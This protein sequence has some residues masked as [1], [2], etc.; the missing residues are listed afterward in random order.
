M[1]SGYTPY[2]I[3]PSDVGLQKDLDSYLI[4]D[5]AF[6]NLDNAYVRRGRVYKKGGY[7]LLGQG[8]KAGRLGTRTIQIGVRSAGAD[9]YN[10][11][12]STNPNDLTIEPGSLIITDGTTTFTDNGTG[13]FTIT[14][15]GVVN[16]P[17]NYT[18]SAINITFSNG[19]N[20]ALVTANYIVAVNDN[21]PVMGLRTYDLANSIFAGLVAFDLTSAYQFNNTTFQF[22]NTRFYKSTNGMNSNLV[23]WSGSDTDFFDS[24]NYQNAMFATNN[25]A[26]SNFYL[27][28]AITQAAAAQV[29][30]SVANNFQAGDIVYFNNVLG[31][32]QINNLT[33]QV[34]VAGNPFTVMINT[35][36]FSAYTNGSGIAWSLVNTKTAGGDG[37]RW[38]D[39]FTAGLAPATGW[40]NFEPP[41][42]SSTVPRPRILQGCLL[43]F[44][45]KDR[46]VCLNTLE[47]TAG[48][49]ATRFSQRAR[50]S[51][52]GNVFYAA[53]FPGTTALTNTN[54]GNEWI[55][56]VPGYGGFRDAPTGQEIIGAELIKDTLVVYFDAST[57]KLTFTGDAV[58]PFIWE[59]INTEIGAESTFSI[60]PFD[61]QLLSVGSNGI[62]ACDSV[63]MERIDR[64]IPDEVFSFVTNATNAKR[65]QGVRDFYAETVQWTFLDDDE[66]SVTSYPYKTLLFNYVNQTFAIFYNSFTCFG[67]FNAF[68]DLEWQNATKPWA[69]YNRTW[70]SFTDTSGFPI[71]VA[72]N[73]QGF[74]F[75]LQNSAGQ[76]IAYNDTSL[77]IQGVTATDPSVFTSTNHNLQPNDFIS[78]VG[79]SLPPD[80]LGDTYVV[81]DDANYTANT[82]ALYDSFGNYVSV[83]DYTYGGQI[84]V[85]DNFLIGTKNF[86]PFFAQGRSMRL[87]Y[88]DFFLDTSQIID[89]DETANI[90]VYLYQ[91]DDPDNPV[92]QYTIDT[93]NPYITMNTKA[94]YRVY[95]ESQGQFLKIVLS[96]SDN[97][98]GVGITP[99]QMF[100]YNNTTYPL[101][102]HGMILWMKPSGRDLYVP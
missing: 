62:Y 24:V 31:M 21:S 43:M 72:G 27:I 6:T 16:G 20:G 96:L 76:K 102:L 56:D 44:V 78:F 45:Y 11:T 14:G 10:L 4:P 63:S 98:S 79:A 73:Q 80:L 88:A 59:K 49:T 52:V 29:T 99:G 33:G 47:S 3:G 67:H 87:G 91:N 40:V 61:R 58:N 30:T 53:P 71:V 17:T 26:G 54:L 83:D 15:A 95:F 34:T 37:I 92:E 100:D 82:F 18:T 81:A 38:Y 89:P 51:Q 68:T 66:N 65:I 97:Y 32:T 1:T 50:W 57:F 42:S 46:L 7:Q 41:L 86:N 90:T 39:G 84:Q 5:T 36:G 12:I 75:Q 85:V 101:V 77:V 13:G 70:D 22:D 74:V 93:M 19:N 23:N 64:I 55:D 9:T 94:W 48:T 60:I 2:F 35:T 69:F 25:I 28:T 8:P